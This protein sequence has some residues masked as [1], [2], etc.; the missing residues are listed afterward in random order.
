MNHLIRYAAMGML[1]ALALGGCHTSDVAPGM[2]GRASPDLTLEIYSV[3]AD[4]TQAIEDALDKALGGIDAKLFGGARASITAAGPGKLLVYAPR[5]AQASIGK[6]IDTLGAATKQAAPIQVGVHFWVIDG[7]PGS[8]DD[9]PMLKQLAGNLDPLR[10]VSGPMHFRLDQAATLVGTSGED[11]SLDTGNKEAPERAFSFRIGAVSNETARLQLNYLDTGAHGLN[12][13]HTFIDATFGQ[14]IVL[15]QA[16]GPCRQPAT[17]TT[18]AG[19]ANGS[20]MRLLVVRVD[21]LH[22]KA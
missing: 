10:Q 7:E 14:Y 22:D 2:S 11:G 20:A 19:C 9:D 16:P 5:D 1:S 18:P 15:A 17:D 21:R 3:P 12:K 6:V 8:G 13:L 4:R